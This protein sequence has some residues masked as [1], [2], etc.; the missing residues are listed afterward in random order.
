MP[1]EGYGPAQ[2]VWGKASRYDHKNPGRTPEG[3]NNFNCKPKVKGALP[4][5]LV[6]RNWRVCL[7]HV[8]SALLLN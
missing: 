4:I 8:G 3:A 1:T 7:R 6:P 5:V 2:T